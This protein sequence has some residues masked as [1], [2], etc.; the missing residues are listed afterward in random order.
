M[1]DIAMWNKDEKSE[2]V[3]NSLEQEGMS[4]I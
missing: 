4:I 1:A 2:E 3:Y